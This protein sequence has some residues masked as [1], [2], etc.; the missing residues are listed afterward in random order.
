MKR[1]HIFSIVLLTL[2][3]CSLCIVLTACKD[4]MQVP[5]SLI[6]DMDTL[7]LN[8][9]RVPGAASYEVSIEGQERTT[10]TQATYISLEHLDPGV[11]EIKVRAISHNEEIEPSEWA[12]CPSFEKKPETGLRYK[13]INNRT[14]YQLTGI[15]TASGDVVMESEFRGKPVTSIADKA[16]NNVQK[17]TSFVVSKNVKEIGKSA[18]AKCNSLLTVSFEEGSQL[19]T[20]GEYAFQSC[21]SLDEVVFPDSLTAIPGYIFS[22]C[23][24]LKSVTLGANVS[25]VGAYAFSNCEALETVNFPEKL[26]A[27]EAYAFSDCVALGEISLGNSIETISEFAFFNCTGLSSIDLGEGLRIIGVG[28]FGGCTKLGEL[29]IPDSVTDIGIQAFHSCTSLSDVTLGTGLRSLGG[30]AFY[31]T[32]AFSE[33]SDGDVIYIDNWAVG[34]KNPELTFITLKQGT[35]GIADYAFLANM[36]LELLNLSGVRYIGNYAFY[37]CTSLMSLICDDALLGI[38]ESAFGS[39][40]LLGTNDIKLGASL[41]T[42]GNYAFQG[43]S[44]ITETNV[45]LPDSLKMIGTY[46]F[47]NTKAF[48][49][50]TDV[51]YIDDWAVGLKEKM[52]T[53]VIVRDG[54]RGIANY[55][56]Y[57]SYVMYSFELPDSVE[58]IGRA[59]FSESMYTSNINL[60]KNLKEIGD[61]AFYSCILAWFGDDGITVIPEG[62]QYVGISAFNRCAKMVGVV[63]PG[64]VKTVGDFAFFKCESLGYVS[65]GS[66]EE[67]SLNGKVVIEDGVET[68]GM[69]VFHGCNALQEITI[70]DSVTSMGARVFYQCESLRKVSIGNGLVYIPDYTFY[71]CTALVDVTFSAGVKVIGKYAFRGCT[72]IRELVIGE[73]IEEIGDYAFYGCLSIRDIVIPRSVE[74][75]GRFAFRGCTGVSSV[76]MPNS[77]EFIGIHAFYGLNRASI[78]CE[79]TTIPSYW[80]ERWN[81]SY[82]PVFWGCDL[83]DDGKRVLSFVKSEQNPENMDSINGIAD[84]Y[85]DGYYF[86]GW[87]TV[88]GGSVE[89]T[90]NTLKSVAAGTT[91]Y[92]VFVESDYF[93]S[94]DSNRPQNATFFPEGVMLQIECLFDTVF[95]LAPSDYSL[96]GWVFKGW[97]TTPDGEVVYQDGAEITEPM[98]DESGATVTLYAVW[99]AKPYTIKFEPAKP[100]IASSDI[101]GVMPDLVTTFDQTIT[102]TPNQFSIQGWRFMGWSSLPFGAPMFADQAVI[103]VGANE[104]ENDTVTLYPI[105]APVTYYI[106]YNVNLPLNA[107]AAEGVM[108]NLICTYDTASIITNEYSL[109][110]YSF[111]GWATS[112]NGSVVYREGDEVLNLTMTEGETIALYAVWQKD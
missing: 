21:K 67:P 87:T 48:T 23:S 12:V 46:A 26:S 1:L 97:S 13:L 5:E 71:G 68:I 25:S 51:V 52:Y 49:D 60:P 6:V 90:A 86:M 80:N 54:T 53:D 57:R 69:R 56:F 85:L 2:L 77:V 112:P 75:I 98:T 16:L 28:A 9:R 101:F 4:T 61:Y 31:N 33:S 17:I 92:P 82:R 59:A 47:H 76:I 108:K 15:G 36:K 110:G 41:E 14:E 22:W 78:F 91:L 27:I 100:Q 29:V 102:L 20:I 3:L 79:D 88:D 42:I 40:V 83:S 105:W 55:A 107:P 64:T 95:S 103:N 89:Y 39:C 11:Y 106:E 38:G 43:C 74:K 93:V 70:P 8:W 18:F 50:A 37:G 99:E 73:G 44:R 24:A 34:V 111:M 81:T 104:Q 94:F 63:I 19:Q 58:Y 35:V 84:P 66:D 45:D 72:G 10:I 96:I 30:E 109:E 32:K 62:T 7:T 65:S